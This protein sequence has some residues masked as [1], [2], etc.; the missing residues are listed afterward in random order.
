MENPRIIYDKEWAKTLE[1][2]E[3]ETIEEEMD[4]Y[5]QYAEL[6]KKFRIN[7]LQTLRGELKKINEKGPGA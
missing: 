5:E 6:E 2:M 4:S 7:R 3:D 1:E